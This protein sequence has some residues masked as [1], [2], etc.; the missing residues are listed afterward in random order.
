MP[1]IGR[2]IHQQLVCHFFY[3]YFVLRFCYLESFSL[4]TN[5]ASMQIHC[6]PLIHPQQINHT[7]TLWQQ[8]ANRFGSQFTPQCDKFIRTRWWDTGP[9]CFNGA[10]SYR[11]DSFRRTDELCCSELCRGTFG[12]FSMHHMLPAWLYPP[13][14][15]RQLRRIILWGFPSI[16][17]PV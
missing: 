10:R 7:N 3:H 14:Y 6:N 1:P 11:H 15:S 2:T 16:L 13:K 17:E 5:N 4:A 9:K 12:M 8:I